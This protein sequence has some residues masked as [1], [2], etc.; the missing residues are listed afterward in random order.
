MLVFDRNDLDEIIDGPA[1]V[2]QERPRLIRTGVKIMLADQLVQ[3][4]PVEFVIDQGNLYDVEVAVVIKHV[5]RVI[6][7]GDAAGH[8]G[9]K[10]AAHRS[11]DDH[12]A[13]RHVFAAMVTCTFHD[14]LGP[15]I[16]DRET[17][18]D[19]ACDI[20]FASRGAV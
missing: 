9:G 5:T 3:F 11:Q 7:V 2:V 8:A 14:G 10:V 13:A 18:A 6:D 1:P 19:T 16:A 4:L 12:A 17:L 15:G 20:H